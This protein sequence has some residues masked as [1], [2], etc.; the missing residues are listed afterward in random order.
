MYNDKN[1]IKRDFMKKILLQLITLFVL[2]N[3]IYGDEKNNRLSY[4]ERHKYVDIRLGVGFSQYSS[5]LDISY[6]LETRDKMDNSNILVGLEMTTISAD[7][8]STELYDLS[9]ARTNL[10][11]NI[12]YSFDKIDIMWGLG[13]SNDNTE[14]ELM[15]QLV[16]DTYWS[17]GEVEK[18]MVISP[19][20]QY[21]FDQQKG[22]FAL[23]LVF[24][25]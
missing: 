6:T 11:M 8:N 1:I 10:I 3:P 19:R 16:L 20:Y 4:E 14:S 17:L 7:N 21:Y 15:T 24:R 18:A 23:F 13:K 12:G 2:I 5:E 22:V 25:H 9:V